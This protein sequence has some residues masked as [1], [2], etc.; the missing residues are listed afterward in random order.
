MLASP[1]YQKQCLTAPVQPSIVWG[2]GFSVINVLQGAP[3]SPALVALNC[4]LLYAYHA[5]QCL[6]G[7]G[8]EPG[9]AN[10]W[11]FSKLALRLGARWEW[12]EFIGEV[13]VVSGEFKDAA[14]LYRVL[15]HRPA[16]H[17]TL[18][19]RIL[20]TGAFLLQ[21]IVAVVVVLMAIQ[22]IL[23]ST[24]PIATIGKLWVVFT[25]L[26][27]D[28][29]L[30]SF[31]LFIFDCE[32][33]FDWEVKLQ[34]QSRRLSPEMRSRTWLLIYW[35]PVTVAVLCVALS[36]CFNICPLTVLH[37][38]AVSNADPVLM[39]SSTFGLPE[40]CCSPQVTDQ[41]ENGVAV[42]VPCVSSSQA[43]RA[44]VYYVVVPDGRPSPSSLQVMEGRG[45]DGNRGLRYGQVTATPLQMRWWLTRHGFDVSVYLAMR[46]STAGG[47]A[48]YQSSFPHLA[49]WTIPDFP[50]THRA[51]IFVAAV[52]PS[53]GAL[54]PA[55]VQSPVIL[56]KVCSP[57]CLRCDSHG[58]CLDCEPGFVA[59]EPPH[60]NSVGDVAPNRVCLPPVLPTAAAVVLRATVRA[61]GARS[62]T[63]ALAYR[64]AGVFHAPIN[65][66]F[67][68]L[69]HNVAAGGLIGAWGVQQGLLGVPFASPVFF[70][71]YRQVTPTMAAF[72]V[73][74]AGAGVLSSILGG[75]G[76]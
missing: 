1:A 58:S 46:K 12:I 16:V 52:N 36:L 42:S 26:D 63:R 25:T 44:L 32:H 76:W 65:A 57:H 13:S 66:R 60:P 50:W 24:T 54:S 69:L 73:Y 64:A 31:I 3:F 68:S 7:F 18:Q 23:T 55:V 59:E 40:G 74:G 20:G 19:Q 33:A 56:R 34:C 28:N 11:S 22:L 30:C 61:L 43:G 21:Y 48:L 51:R 27:F 14:K 37:Y 4:G 71:R 8:A 49:E 75:K 2:C 17:M 70:L 9:E 15:A 39:L 5:L 35:A 6:G 67:A 38:G 45:G 62:V 29:Y 41:A 53:T 72:F 47:L 10:Q